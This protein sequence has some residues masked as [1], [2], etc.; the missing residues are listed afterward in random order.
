MVTFGR[1][2]KIQRIMYPLLQQFGGGKEFFITS[3]VSN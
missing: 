1:F 3:P 2:A